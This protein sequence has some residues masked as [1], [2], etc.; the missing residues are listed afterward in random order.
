MCVQTGEGEMVLVDPRLLEQHKRLVETQL[1]QEVARTVCCPGLPDPDTDPATQHEWANKLNLAR[2]GKNS[3]RRFF[4]HLEEIP[5][6]SRHSTFRP[7]IRNIPCY[8]FTLS[9][10]PSPTEHS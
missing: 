5:E 3:S 7:A 6:E 9:C 8:T 2:N 4:P 10:E 1:Q